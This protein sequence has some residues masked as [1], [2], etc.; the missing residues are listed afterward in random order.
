M[1]PS[2][3][4]ALFNFDHGFDQPRRFRFGPYEFEVT[5]DHVTSAERLSR[6][7]LVHQ[8]WDAAGRPVV[9]EEAAKAGEMVE[10][11][12]VRLVDLIPFGHP[13]LGGPPDDSEIGELCTVLSFLTGRPVLAES[14]RTGLE[15]TYYGDRVVG[16]NY[17]WT[18][19]THW[20]DLEAIKRA[21]LGPALW[22]LV[23]GL[24][25]NDLIGRMCYA[26]AALDLIVTNWS[27]NQPESSTPELKEKLRAT[28]NALELT[29][30]AELGDSD[31][32]KDAIARLGGLFSPSALAKLMTFL[33]NEKYLPALPSSDEIRRVKL[34]NA[35][36]N[37]VVHTADIPSDIHDELKRRAEIAAYAL[38]VAKEICCVYLSDVMRV[39]DSQIEMSRKEIGRFFSQGRFN[40]HRVFDEDYAAFVARIKEDWVAAMLDD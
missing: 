35:T 40:G 25:T 39:K 3:A 24:S 11:A 7:G 15:G 20:P 16:R 6:H 9:V 21:G 32:A 17:F 1:S 12:T 10:T 37:R 2:A 36:R 28:R 31:M 8:T 33:K 18:V 26:S 23:K 13:F 34:L 14:E 5:A 30:R 38:A 22:A 27:K 4:V 19:G 29:I